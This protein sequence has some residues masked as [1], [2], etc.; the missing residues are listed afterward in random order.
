MVTSA[1]KVIIN[2]LVAAMSLL[3]GG[4]VT[5]CDNTISTSPSASASIAFDDLRIPGVLI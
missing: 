2:G 1:G 3:R 4:E 5:K